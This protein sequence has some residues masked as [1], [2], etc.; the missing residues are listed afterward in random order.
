MDQFTSFR[1]LF[2]LFLRLSEKGIQKSLQKYEQVEVVVNDGDTAWEIQKRLTPNE[3][4]RIPL[5]LA[6]KLNPGVKMGKLYPGQ[7]IIM[8]KSKE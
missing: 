8:L 7:K 1:M 2:N 5:Y 6:E 3:D 4:V